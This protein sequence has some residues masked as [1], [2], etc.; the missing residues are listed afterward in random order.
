MVQSY[1]HTCI[2]SEFFQRTRAG[3]Q[4]PIMTLHLEQRFQRLKRNSITF[5][6]KKRKKMKPNPL[7]TIFWEDRCAACDAL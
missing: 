3:I 2:S 6:K 5:L 1:L 7:I 4:N